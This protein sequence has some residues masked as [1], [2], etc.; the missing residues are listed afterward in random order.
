MD[1]AKIFI[2]YFIFI[3]NVMCI[4]HTLVVEKEID[5]KFTISHRSFHDIKHKF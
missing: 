2:L 3:L 5:K 4:R 1:L